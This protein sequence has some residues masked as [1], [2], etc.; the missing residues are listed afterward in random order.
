V[1]D[2]GWVTDEIR[3]DVLPRIPGGRIGEGA[4]AARLIGWLCSADAA[5]VT[6]QV[7]ASEGGFIRR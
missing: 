4:D 1:T 6:G 3:A 5:W 2:T 7:I